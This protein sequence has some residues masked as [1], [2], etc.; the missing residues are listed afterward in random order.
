[1]FKFF[2]VLQLCVEFLCVCFYLS[3]YLSGE[4]Y[5]RDSHVMGKFMLIPFKIADVPP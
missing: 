5:T 3:H 2:P 1:M 4:Y